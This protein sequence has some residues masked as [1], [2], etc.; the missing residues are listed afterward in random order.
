MKRFDSQSCMMLMKQIDQALQLHRQERI[1]MELTL[2][3][4]PVSSII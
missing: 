1:N 2:E 4:T 3:V